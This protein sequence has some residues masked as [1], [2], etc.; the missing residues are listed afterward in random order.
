MANPKNM[1]AV[2]K[3]LIL[4]ANPKT[5]P[6]LRLDEE[7]REIREGLKRA[8]R[9]EQFEIHQNWAVRLLDLRRALLD[10]EPQIVHFT[11]HGKEDGLLVEDELGMAVSISPPT[12]SGLFELFA[13]QVECVLLNACYSEPQ[14]NA[15]SRHID[16]VI[17]MREEIDDKAAIQFAVGFYDALGA[18]KPVEEAFNFGCNA[19]QL[20]NIPGHL[21]P[22]L[23][24]KGSIE[25]STGEAGDPPQEEFPLNPFGDVH[26]IRDPGRFIGRESELTRLRK[27]L[28]RSS[29]ALRGEPKIGKSS[30]LLHL[31]HT[32]KG[33]TIGPINCLNLVDQEDFFEQIAKTLD[34]DR[35]DWRT[36]RPVLS[37]K[38]ILLLIDE[39]DVAPKRGLN[40]DKMNL[41]RAVC[42]DNPDFKIVAVSRTPL[43][44]VFPDQDRG[45]PFYNILQPI[46]LGP[47][48]RSEAL[49][50]LSH[51][52]DS[53][54]KNFDA[55]TC[56]NL[57]KITGCHPFKL[58]NAA[59]HRYEALDNPTYDWVVEYQK[60]MDQML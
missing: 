5:T 54:S 40:Q 56:E 10:V 45:S 16:Y 15:I 3:I 27:V 30:L 22:L 11:G 38:Q 23:L 58:Q 44:E 4:A 14:A 2:K 1:N 36:I 17:G 47:M 32:W 8:K 21:V 39:L 50:L 24:T 13:N 33:E 19:I 20:Y 59:F 60:D 53:K 28:R 29:V 12:L 51:P 42:Q 49:L 9:R 18:G 52:W 34:L 35:A 43:K 41:F 46:E 6:R 48:T 55:P 26:A 25:P 37:D 57:L 7:V 31:A